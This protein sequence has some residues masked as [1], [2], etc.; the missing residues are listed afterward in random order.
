[1][2]YYNYKGIEYEP[3]MTIKVEII[4]MLGDKVKLINN[5]CTMI[6]I[7]NIFNNTGLTNIGSIIINDYVWSNICNYYHDLPDDSDDDDDNFDKLSKETISWNMSTP[8]KRFANEPS[9]LSILGK[10]YNKDYVT[11]QLIL[12][13]H[14][15]YINHTS[16][17]YM[18]Q[19]YE[20]LFINI[21]EYE[22]YDE[23][24]CINIP[25]HFNNFK[26]Y[27]AKLNNKCISFDDYEQIKRFLKRSLKMYK[28]NE[29]RLTIMLDEIQKFV[30]L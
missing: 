26:K 21:Y 4:N 8:F 13:S 3:N 22:V 17:V 2:H 12:V 27:I 18:A 7:D 5:E 24:L 20:E 19:L 9:M 1:M 30:I 15:H 25:Q 29:K 14:I 11:V 10:D 6:D 23:D 28:F 16:A